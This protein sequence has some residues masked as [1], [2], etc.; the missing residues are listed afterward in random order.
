MTRLRAAEWSGKVDSSG[1]GVLMAPDENHPGQAERNQVGIS[2][3]LKRHGSCWLVPRSSSQCLP[4]RPRLG[5]AR[6]A[7]LSSTN[8]CGSQAVARLNSIKSTIGR[9]PPW[10]IPYPL[11]R[12]S[13]IE[14]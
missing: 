10:P 4:P 1:S 9:R 11:R 3:G 2:A 8:T 12:R 13:M 6:K 7:A 5:E 14:H